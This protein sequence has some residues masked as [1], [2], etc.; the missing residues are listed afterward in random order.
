MKFRSVQ[1]LTGDNLWLWIMALATGI[2]LALP[3]IGLLVGLV[4]T[5]IVVGGLSLTTWRTRGTLGPG[6]YK[7]MVQIGV[8]FLVWISLPATIRWWL[9]ALGE[10]LR[11]P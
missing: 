2:G 10:L 11:L 1:F 7:T 5:L 6:W 8:V 3:R 9:P 4:W